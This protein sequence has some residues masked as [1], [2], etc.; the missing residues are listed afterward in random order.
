MKFLFF[1]TIILSVYAADIC[2][3]PTHDA[4]VTTRRDI[5]AIN[6]S[7]HRDEYYEGEFLHVWFD[8]SVKKTLVHVYE[9]EWFNHRGDTHHYFHLRDYSKKYLWRG[10]Y[11]FTTKTTSNCRLELMDRSFEPY[12]PAKGVNLTH[13]GTV[14]KSAKVDFYEVKYDD[15]QYHFVEDINLITETGSQSLIMQEKVFGEFF[16]TTTEVTWYWVE[17]R[18]WFDLKETITDKTIFNVP[19]GCPNP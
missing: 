9:K 8:S 11:N 19:A 13:S 5:N 15:P 10:H 6:M 16:N 12:C 17:H 2:L 1:L 3:P 18:E 7:H 4:V 14:G